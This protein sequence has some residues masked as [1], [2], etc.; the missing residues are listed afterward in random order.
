M[1][2]VLCDDHRLFAEAFAAVLAAS[3]HTVAAVA[4]T[5]SGGVGAVCEHQPDLAVFDMGFPVSNGIE[6]LAQIRQRAPGIAVVFLSG[7]SDPRSAANAIHHGARAYLDKGQNAR[8]ILHSLERLHRG[9]AVVSCGSRSG[10]TSP[11]RQADD[12]RRL[13]AFLAPREREVLI[14]LVAGRSTDE[15]ASRLNI[16]RSTTRTHVQGLLSKL[17]ASSRLEAAA[18]VADSGLLQDPGF[19]RVRS[20]G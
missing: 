14:E 2:T 13:A 6:A 16:S 18:L 15:I 5:V 11:D 7:S 19:A 20:R 3:G 12:V 10:C 9:E 8:T 1:K 4:D 17:G